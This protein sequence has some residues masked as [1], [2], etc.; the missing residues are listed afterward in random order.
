MLV[1]ALDTSTSIGGVCLLTRDSVVANRSFDSGVRHCQQLFLE[2][3]EM[4]AVAGCEPNDVDLVA[5]TIGPGSFT[6]LRIGLAAAKGICFA[7]RKPLV[8]VPTLEVLASRL[9]FSEQPVCAI[10]DA[11]KN[12]VYTATYDMTNLYPKELSPAR[13]VEPEALIAEFDHH[14]ICTGNGAQVYA[15]MLDQSPVVKQAPIH[16][17]SMDAVPV[18][19]LALRNFDDDQLADLDSVEP[20]YVRAPDARHPRPTSLIGH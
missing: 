10:I 3:D 17:S 4:C 15:A 11:R 8:T 9:P 13:A 12:Q 20:L 19:W 14:V 16:C 5:T 6:G 7:A 2:I 1:L 18:G